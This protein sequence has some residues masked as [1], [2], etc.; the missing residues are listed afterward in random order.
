MARDSS[1]GKREGKAVDAAAKG[2]GKG[3]RGEAPRTGE[4]AQTPQ[5]SWAGRNAG[6]LYIVGAFGIIVLIAVMKASCN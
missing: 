1:G 6:T 3:E 5:K 2:S 4:E